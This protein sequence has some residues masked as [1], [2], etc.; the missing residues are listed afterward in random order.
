MNEK[1]SI[2]MPVKNT[3]HFLSETISSIL[4]QTEKNWELIAVN[5]HS[6]DNSK[7]V[8][9]S[10]AQNDKRIKVID[11]KGNGIIDALQ[12]GYVF[13]NGNFI[14]RMDSDDIMSPNK[15]ETQ[16][17]QLLQFGKNHIALG[18]VKYFSNAPLGDGYKK[19]ET[20]LN[21]L[22][23]KGLNFSDI[24]KECVIASPCWMVF[25]EDFDKCGGFNSSIYPED[26]DLTF[27]FYKNK[28]ICIPSQ[29]ILHYWRDY[30]ERTSRNDVHYA[31][32]SFINI[33][34]NHFLTIDYNNTKKLIIWGAGKKGKKIAQQLIEKKIPFDWICDNPKK[35]GKH[36]YNQLMLDYKTVDDYINYQSIITVANSDFQKDIK[37]FLGKMNLLQG[38]DFFFFC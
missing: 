21:K 10:F 25:R 6:T 15:L 8:L 2:I 19:Y 17:N 1:I 23:N 3:A 4:N 18:L 31:D 34:L 9:T 5:D 32:S 24:Y 37:K 36:I 20:W 29:E 28:L 38:R 11:N 35:I 16:K 26:Y 14:T 27:R 7:D 12:L 13:S 22:T 30:P 33:K